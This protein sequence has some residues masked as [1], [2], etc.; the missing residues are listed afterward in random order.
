MKK[1]GA[2]TEAI[3]VKMTVERDNG[4]KKKVAQQKEKMRRE[5]KEKKLK[6]SEGYSRR[7]Q[8]LQWNKKQVFPLRDTGSLEREREVK[9]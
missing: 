4:E 7:N 8:K 2:I 5:M 9:A 1:R 3:K 6:F